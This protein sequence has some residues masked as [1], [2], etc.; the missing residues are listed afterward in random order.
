M[1]SKAFS[2]G[3]EAVAATLFTYAGAKFA[4]G[5]RFPYRDIGVIE[6]DLK[7][8]WQAERIEFVGKPY[9][10]KAPAPKPPQSNQQR[11]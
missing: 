7:G 8:L 2:P 3:S 6:F 10:D 1:S 9:V 4:K 11:R 5:D